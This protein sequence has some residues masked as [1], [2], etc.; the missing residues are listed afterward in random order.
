V[1]GESAY[2][3]SPELLA[4]ES[5]LSYSALSTQDARFEEG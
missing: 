1:I 4:L 5:A 3:F 2:R